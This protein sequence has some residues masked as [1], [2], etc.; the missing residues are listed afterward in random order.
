MT[1]RGPNAPHPTRERFARIREV[2]TLA[3]ECRDDERT[4]LLAAQCGNDAD[5]L[6]SVQELLDAAR[7]APERFGPDDG[8]IARQLF[9]EPSAN[10]AAAPDMPREIGPYHIR[11][12]IGEGGMGIVYLAQQSN[13]QREVALKLLRAGPGAAAL[14]SRFGRE[15]RVLGRLEHPGIARI[16]EAGTATTPGG[17]V[18]Y[19]AME[20]VRGLRLTDYA[21]KMNLGIPERVE[22]IAKIA[23]AAQHAHTKGIIHRDLKPAN[24]LVADEAT[25][26]RDASHTRS[27]DAQ[28]KILDFG[29][30]RMAEPDTQHTALTEAGLLIGTV[31]YMSPEQLSGDNDAVDARSDVYAIGVMLYELLTGCPPHDIR[32]KPIPEAARI[33]RDE[34]PAT[35]NATM[36]SGSP[37]FD[38]DLETI[39]ARAIARDR[40]RRYETAAA[41]A[42]DLRRYLRHEP[43]LAR[44]ATIAY[45]VSKFA[46]RH[47]A[48]VAA[49]LLVIATLVL[50]VVAMS[51]VTLAA[52]RDRDT[53][54]RKTAV[55]EGVS[56][57]LLNALTTATPRSSPG[58]EPRLIDAIARIEDQADDPDGSRSPEVRAVVLNIV[59]IIYRER[60]DYAAADRNFT[61]ALRIHRS[62]LAPDDPNLA[63]SLNNLGLLRMRQGRTAEAPPFYQEAVD[64]Q[65]KSSFR[66][67]ARLARNL[68]NLSTAYIAA[69]DTARARPLLDESLAMHRQLPG[70]R[71]EVIGFHISAQSRLARAEGRWVDALPLAEEAL[72]IQRDAVGPIHPSIATCLAD[73]AEIHQHAGENTRALELLRDAEA[74][75]RQVFPTNPTHPVA[76]R[77]R[78]AL[79]TALRAAGSAEEADRLEQDA[80]GNKPGQ[81][82]P[83]SS[84]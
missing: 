66:D 19:F 16:Y 46:R 20:Y 8:D 9:E 15:V 50:A 30:A 36:S 84:P 14:R 12:V 65:R 29:V 59:G 39:V 13:P 23:D 80:A 35:L 71:R 64:L 61:E 56:Q 62:V 74:M 22:L 33:V 49:A 41:F 73:V 48:L 6:A 37:R 38:R 52:R 25:S 51:I 4:E 70:D 69:G 76:T 58:K 44:P 28:P 42:D 32:S 10:A 5:L 82:E 24:I 72:R 18:S 47:R 26:I 1:T 55:S 57:V 17:P 81:P 75:T 54:V 43:I 68:Y 34:D 31:S 7:A 27:H 3:S 63:D 2:F 78:T 79:V 83:R 21:A 60:A 45:Q 40:D 11:S 53:A 67:D 77:I